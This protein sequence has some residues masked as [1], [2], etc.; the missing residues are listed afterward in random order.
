MSF[1]FSTRSV[2]VLASLAI[3]VLFTVDLNGQVAMRTMTPARAVVVQS[4]SSPAASSAQAAAASK[5]AAAEGED[6]K[7]KEPE[8]SF[9]ERRIEALL[10]AN[11]DRSLP[12]V[13][14]EWSAKEE[15]EEETKKKEPKKK[16][17]AT[18]KVANIYE[19]FVVLEF[20][21][22]P[23]FKKDE[24]V[25]V[26]A[27]EKLIGT[28]AILS[29]EENKVSGKF[30]AVKKEEDKEKASDA[31]AAE[32]KVDAKAAKEEAPA[33][34][35]EAKD[36][37]KDTAEK[38]TKPEGVEA[39]KAEGKEEEKADAAASTDATAAPE[40]PAKETAEAKPWAS[41]KADVAVTVKK[42][43]DGSAKK[44]AKKAAEEAQ[45]KTEVAQWSK[46]ITL[47]KWTEVK[48]YLT[49]LKDDDADKLYAHLLTKLASTPGVNE[50]EGGSR[51]S[52]NDR[53]TPLS[54]FLSPEDILQVT[55]AA[56][57]PWKISITGNKKFKGL[58]KQVAGKW[59]GKV[60][61]EGAGVPAGAVMPEIAV[62]LDLQLNGDAVTGTVAVSS[63][64]QE[65]SAEIESGTYDAESGSLTLS[66]TAEG[67]T[68]VGELTVE[69]GTMSGTLSSDE[70][71]PTLRFE[72]EL[73]EPAEQPD[74]E[75]DDEEIAADDSSGETKLPPGV[76]NFIRC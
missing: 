75:D 6:G 49:S 38:E 12:T 63:M 56:P 44:A 30:E 62:T 7:P 43:D 42:P 29:V 61:L 1:L 68:M 33:A 41:L 9:D 67:S 36:K 58:G 46:M 21:K 47:G 19:D 74:A 73:V 37:P 10:K 59:K 50:E 26:H 45:I 24:K 5:A 71:G 3:A 72:G 18:A 11:I 65:Q 39:T 52:R 31:K 57:K 20:E 54:N 27:D 22:K 35:E 48:T 28:V 2:S 34:V 69:D 16:K 32:K 25:E 4:S 60:T 15:K 64:G 17:P 76:D 13:L 40:E 66:A 70:G 14:K 23:A 55:D 8:K 53:E 51:R